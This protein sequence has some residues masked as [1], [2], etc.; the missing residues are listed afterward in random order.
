MEALH[1]VQVLQLRL[2]ISCNGLI[3][4]AHRQL[5]C[6][7]ATKAGVGGLFGTIRCH[8]HETQAK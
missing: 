8:S 1:C 5:G 7:F 3:S 2:A 4:V 6:C